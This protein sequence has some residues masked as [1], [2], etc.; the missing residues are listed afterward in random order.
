MKSTHLMVL[1][2]DAPGTA[3][4]R[5]EATPAHLRHIES[6][7]DRLA[8][9]GPLY[10]EDGGCIVGSLY[11]FA[12]ADAGQ[13]REWLEQDPYFTAGL[14]RSVEYRPFLPAAG[15]WAGGKIW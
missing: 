13:A 1:C 8:V 6:I 2:H 11:V 15:G 12:T 4:R 3:E 9:A 14:W 7:L 5:R 10:S